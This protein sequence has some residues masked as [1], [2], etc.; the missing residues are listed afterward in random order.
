LCCLLS[1]DA[2]AARRRVCPLRALLGSLGRTATVPWRAAAAGGGGASVV[3]AA[4]WA[5]LQA[6]ARPGIAPLAPPRARPAH[7]EEDEVVAQACP[8]PT[9][10]PAPDRSLIEALRVGLRRVAEL[11]D[12]TLWG[13]L[14]GAI[15]WVAGLLTPP[16]IT[17]GVL[18]RLEG[19]GRRG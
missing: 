7:E 8:Q 10:C 18:R 5:G 11:D 17:P 6:L 16:R 4:V 9:P 14:T 2:I 12:V 1:P 3:S 15:A 19:Y 13:L